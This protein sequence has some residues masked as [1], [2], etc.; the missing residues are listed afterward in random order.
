MQWTGILVAEEYGGAGGTVSDAAV[1]YHEMGRELVPSP[2]LSSSVLAARILADVGT[3]EQKTRLLPSISTGRQI[4]VPAIADT[5]EWGL[6]LTQSSARRAD[7]S[8]VLNGL[9]QFV[10]DAGQADFLIFAASSNDSGAM[11]LFLV[12]PNERGVTMR[13]MTGWTSQPQYEVELQDVTVSDKDII[14]S[15][16]HGWEAIQPAVQ[17]ATLLLSAYVAGAAERAYEMTID[18]AHHRVQF[19]QSIS[20]FQRVQ[21]RV[22][23]QR[24]QADAA[25]LTVQEAVDYLERNDPETE[26]RISLAKALASEGFYQTCESAHHVHAG[27]GSVKDHGLYLYTKASHS[28]YHYLGSPD[29][30]EERVGQLLAAQPA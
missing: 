3:E 20:R 12:D 11:S 7:D 6:A 2:H 24:N 22:I 16:G 8:Y 21:D 29:Y 14:G 27:I 28:L 5:D 25:A 10:A 19:G 23:S 9:K 15:I 4:V 30:H 17:T 13:R 18:Y 1:I 26:L